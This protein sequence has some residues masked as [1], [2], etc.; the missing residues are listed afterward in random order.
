[1]PSTCAHYSI[2]PDRGGGASAHCTCGWRSP[3]APS[4]GVAGGQWDTHR[5]EAD[6]EAVRNASDRR[7]NRDI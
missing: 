3:P 5:A 1:M 6:A 2:E 4:A 7:R